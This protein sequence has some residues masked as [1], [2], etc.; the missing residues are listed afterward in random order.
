[1]AIKA[2]PQNYACSDRKAELAVKRS[3]SP[4][5][6]RAKLLHHHVVTG[7]IAVEKT[8]VSASYS[9]KK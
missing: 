9:K 6:F 8:L 3:I 2:M 4:V 5:L 1:M 7:I